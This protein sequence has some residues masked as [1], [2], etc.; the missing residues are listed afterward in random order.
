MKKALVDRQARFDIEIDNVLDTGIQSIQDALDIWRPLC[1]EM[2]PKKG[3]DGLY[4][5]SR[6]IHYIEPESESMFFLLFQ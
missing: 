5:L 3:K 6:S 2:E 4:F 1:T